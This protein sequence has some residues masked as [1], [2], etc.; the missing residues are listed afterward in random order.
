MGA[1]GLA[2]VAQDKG[3]LNAVVKAV[4]NHRIL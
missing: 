1:V 4:I 2:D 3:K